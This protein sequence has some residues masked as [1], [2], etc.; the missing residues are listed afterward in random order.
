MHIDFDN[1]IYD[2]IILF[3]NNVTSFTDDVTFFF[4]WWISDYIIHKN[5]AFKEGLDWINLL[6]G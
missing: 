5:E 3:T 4:F 1:V 2:N 6:A